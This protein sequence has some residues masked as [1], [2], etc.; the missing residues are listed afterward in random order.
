MVTFLNNISQ[1]K[2]S[3]GGL[4]KAFFFIIWHYKKGGSE[5]RNGLSQFILLEAN[6]QQ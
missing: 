4:N 1:T 3:V 2:A 5:S 6:Y